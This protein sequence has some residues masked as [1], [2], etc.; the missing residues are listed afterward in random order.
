MARF[1]LQQVADACGGR[2]ESAFAQTEVN[3]VCSD[4]RKLCQDQLFVALKGARFDGHDYIASA[5]QLGAAGAVSERKMP[6]Q[7][8]VV[9]PDTLR[10]LG[11]LAR[12]Y[13]ESLKIKV[14]GITGSVGKTTTKEMIAGILDT[15]YRTARTEGNYNNNVGLPQ[16][17]LE[18]QADDQAAVLEMGMNH[19]N[20]MSYLTQIAR[21]D[22]AVITNIG[23]MHIEHLGSREGILQAK[24]EILEG[25]QA[26]GRTVFNGDEPLLWNLKGYNRV[27]PLYF[28]I[29]NDAC[30][31]VAKD[32]QT[33]DGGMNF[34]VAAFG[35]EMEVFVPA[36]GVHMVYN[37]LAA[38]C[39][40]YLMDI[41]PAKMQRA[42]AMFRNA[43]MRQEIFQKD[44]Y[45]IIADCYN[46]GPESM[47]AALQVLSSTQT[48]GRR[49]AVLGDMLEL[50]V[51]SQAEHYRIGRLAA[52]MTD[53]VFTYGKMGDRYSSGAVTGG[54]DQ[55]RVTSYKTHEDLADALKRFAKPGD[56][57]L[58]KGSRGMRMEQALELFFTKEKK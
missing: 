40:G 35:D 3:G 39:V 44:G 18:I 13:R 21:P 15:A 56:V 48:Q 22:I 7:P 14:I 53:A 58:F 25:L 31:V 55:K 23:T 20:E 33:V 8:V 19:F 28:G 45:T 36:P 49:I 29:E 30:D 51:C 52:K 12:Y 2:V 4:S 11:D 41:K 6:G 47:E 17:V 46:A 5:L 1:T 57:L 9:V 26:D 16:T 37:A 54:M 42:L 34:R 32:V 43:G 27:T 50:G 10:A 24:L 38:I